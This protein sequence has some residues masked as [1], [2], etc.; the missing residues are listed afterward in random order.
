ML[1]ITTKADLDRLMTEA[2]GESLTLE[3]KASAALART[4]AEVNELCKDVSALANSAGGQIIYGVQEDRR[5]GTFQLDGGVTDGRITREWIDQIL[6][7]NIQPRIDRARISS[8]DLGS[9]GRAFVLTVPQSNTGPHQAPDHRYYKRFELR[10]A[11][12]E[13]YEIKDVMRRATTPELFTTLLFDGAQPTHTIIEQGERSR[14]VIIHVTIGN[15]SPQ[16]AHFVISDV[17]LD[18]DFVIPFAL[19]K[20]KF[21]GVRNHQPRYRRTIIAPPE[22][23]IFREAE[24]EEYTAQIAVQFPME[25]LKGE[26]LFELES[27]ILTP[28][29]TTVERWKIH[30]RRG[31]VEMCPPGHPK[32]R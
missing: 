15:R 31:E 7:S 24:S 19:P 29:F 28:G 10:A 11:P 6:G 30:Y 20:Y 18:R 1:D 12:M 21:V 3:Y 27:A 14:P 8:I 9:G 22:L 25:F 17:A 5:Q 2:V 4:S 32:N 16:P 26:A 23:P 13:D